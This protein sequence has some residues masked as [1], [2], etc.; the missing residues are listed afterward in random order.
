MS[1]MIRGRA[2]SPA[3]SASATAGFSKWSWVIGLSALLY[4][5][6][7]M[8]LPSFWTDEAAT[9]SAVKRELL[10]LN[11]MLGTVDA[12]HGAYYYLMFGWTRLFGFSE[13]ALR[14]PS[15]IAI[16]CSAVLL[17]ELGRRVGGKPLGVLAATLLV[18]MP[19][20]QYAA[21]DARS[22]ALT[23]LGAVAAS[24]LLVS[25]RQSPRPAKWVGYAIVGATTVSL[26]FYC[27]FLFCAH[28]L[29]VLLDAK[30]RG[31]WRHML[32]SSVAWVAPAL[33]LGWV[34]SRQQFQISWIRDVGPAFPFE[35]V[36]LQFFA[37]GYFSEGGKIVPTPTPGEDFS[38]VAL[39]IMIWAAAAVG[40]VWYRHHFLVLLAV[41][42]L[43]VPALA[44]IGGSL[45][46]GGN[47]YLPRYLTFVL[48]ALALLAAAPV[49]K[50]PTA[51]I[52]SNRNLK[53]PVVAV[54]TLVVFV[55]CLPSYLSQRTEYGRDRQDDFRF[56]AQSVLK[57]GRPGDSFVMSPGSDLAYQ[58]YPEAFAGLGDPTLGIT[59]ARWKR[60]FNQRFDIPASAD[61]IRQYRTVILIEKSGEVAMA[62]ALEE[63]GYAP[64]ERHQG[65]STTVTKLSR[66]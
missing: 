45:V 49:L 35:L 5:G 13:T 23:L 11:A 56:V 61:R 27:V 55:L 53:L 7:G 4:S 40:T 65:P 58:A 39:A 57:L 43:V 12:V 31:Q 41:P 46:T 51:L 26:S 6:Y 60:I 20:T 21:T 34:A 3:G 50:L 8:W 59:A 66:G 54:T 64:V 17:F 33:F 16:S 2:L 22:Y 19:R 9:V 47:Y 37:D 10:D 42:W 38:M 25:I 1:K 14:A 48:P 30:L 29:T 62:E 32:A 28:A 63:M 18:L 36:F 24:Y 52:R 15:L 44:V